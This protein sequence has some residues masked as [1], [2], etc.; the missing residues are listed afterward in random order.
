MTIL[1]DKLNYK[2]LALIAFEFPF[3]NSLQRT[4]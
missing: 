2:I 1:I 3:I 4:F